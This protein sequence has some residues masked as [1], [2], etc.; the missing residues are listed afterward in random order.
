M[1]ISKTLWVS[2]ISLIYSFASSKPLSMIFQVLGETCLYFV[3]FWNPHYVARLHKAGLDYRKE[4]EFLNSR[5]VKRDD[6]SVF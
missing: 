2:K 6:F 4:F 5:K 1:I 3:N